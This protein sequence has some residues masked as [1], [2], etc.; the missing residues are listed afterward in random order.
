MS[1][2][3]GPIHYWMYDKIQVQEEMIRRLAAA[4]EKN[5]WLTAAETTAY[6]N[7]ETR[8]LDAL[9][10]TSNIHGWLSACIENVETRY[11]AL[12]TKLLAQHEERLDTL[13]EILFAFGTEKSTGNQ[14]TAQECYK[15]IDSCTLDGMPCD[16]VNIVTDDSDDSFTWEQRFDVH[17]AYWTKA[18][19]NPAHYYHLRNHFVAGLLSQTAFTLAAESNR[20]KLLAC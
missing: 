13:T 19:G 18:G 1:A 7:E 5:G 11:A 17:S 4:A 2:F 10:D 12:V 20:Y 14:A 6:K 15:L 9:I 8:P 3:L 16:G